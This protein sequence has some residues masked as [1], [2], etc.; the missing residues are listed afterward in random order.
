MRI[1]TARKLYLSLGYKKKG[2][3]AF[4]TIMQRSNKRIK[5]TINI[6]NRL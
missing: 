5:K 4:D 3:K 6:I 2:K 1:R